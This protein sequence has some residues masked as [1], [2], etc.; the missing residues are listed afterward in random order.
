MDDNILL[1]ISGDIADRSNF[2]NFITR[3]IQFFKFKN[4]KSL[5]VHEAA[6]FTR[7]QYAEALRKAPYQVNSLLSGFDSIEGAQLFW[8][9]YLGTLQR[10]KYGAHGYAAYFVLSVMAEFYKPD[11][12]LEEAKQI[13]NHCV[14]ELRTRFMIAQDHFVVK[15][16]D[17]NGVRNLNN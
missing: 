4:G 16:I 8:L 5:S 10:V 12:N 1:S 2:G 6:E 9:D 13:I 17:Q 7:N 15:V 3:N 11:L 14:N